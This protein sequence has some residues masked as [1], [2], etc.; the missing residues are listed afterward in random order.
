MSCQG[1]GYQSAPRNSPG[2]YT[3]RSGGSGKWP[4]VR[5]LLVV[6]TALVGLAR[7][8]QQPL[9]NRSGSGCG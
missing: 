3:G 2:P 9:G 6:G 8:N 1:E 7:H 4:M 5:A